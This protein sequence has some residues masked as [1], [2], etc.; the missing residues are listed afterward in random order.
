M[1]LRVAED[2]LD[3]ALPP[4]VSGFELVDGQPVPATSVAHRHGQV[5][6]DLVW[7]LKSHLLEHAIGGRVYV[8]AGYVLGLPSDRER[9]RAPDV[10]Y[11]SEDTLRRHGPPPE[12]GFWRAVPDFI[13]EIRSPQSGQIRQRI[14]DFLDAGTRL[15]WM[16]DPASRTATVTTPAAR[17]ST[18]GPVTR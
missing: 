5:A 17:S 1:R 3:L 15:A 4:G 10:S 2:V 9:L 7:L 16:I 6:A 18:R 8:E 12:R 11:V 13:V 14:R